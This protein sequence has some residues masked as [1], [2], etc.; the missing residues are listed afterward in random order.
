MTAKNEK[1]K[2][3]KE[4]DLFGLSDTLTE[5]SCWEDLSLV[6]SEIV[7]NVAN[8]IQ[9]HWID[10]TDHSK[11]RVL[12]DYLAD[13]DANKVLANIQDYEKYN[14]GYSYTQSVMMLAE[15]IYEELL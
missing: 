6:E 8:V 4:N 1:E 15:D 14:K 7:T 3:I 9:H 12:I 5:D 11:N 13:T 2:Y 10:N